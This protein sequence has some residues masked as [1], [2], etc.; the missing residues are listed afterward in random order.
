M[1]GDIRGGPKLQAESGYVVTDWVNNVL[2]T[3]PTEEE[4][5]DFVNKRAESDA[6]HSAREE[7]LGSIT[8][9]EKYGN[10]TG[11]LHSEEG[12]E[13][14]DFYRDEA[15]Q[16]YYVDVGVGEEDEDGGTPGFVKWTLPGGENYKEISFYDNNVVGK[17]VEREHFGPDGTFAH[18][19][20]KDRTMK[21]K[22]TLF[23]EEIQ[24]DRHDIGRRQ[25]YA[26]LDREGKVEDPRKKIVEPALKEIDELEEKIESVKDCLLYTSPSPRD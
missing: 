7:F 4:A 10:F 15:A 2:G 21:G 11:F 13:K 17:N 3:F 16:E 6:L 23:I 19:R 18:V 20:I 8:L 1:S 14:Y 5:H 25:G 9:E 22:D 24:S 12:Q 26:S